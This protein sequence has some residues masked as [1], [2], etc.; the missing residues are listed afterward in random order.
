MIDFS[1]IKVPEP[2]DGSVDPITLFHNLKVSDRGINDLWLAQGDALREWH[3]HRN[4]SDIGIVLNTGAGKTLVGLLVAQS[5][6]NETKGKVL[7]ACSSIQLV[8]Q[9]KEKAEGYGLKASTYYRS[10][11]SDDLYSRCIAPCITTYHALFNGL[12]VFNKEDISAVVFDDSHTAEH[13]LRDH[14]SVLI[15]KSKFPDLYAEMLHIFDDYFAYIGRSV[16]LQDTVEGRSKWVL[17]VPPFEVSAQSNELTRV[18]LD[19]GIQ[20]AAETKFAWAHLK[21]NVDQSC[22]FISSSGVTITPAFV[23]ASSLPYFSTTVR[24]VYLSATMSAPDAFTRTFGKQPSRIV[25]PAT[26]AGECERLIVLPSRIDSSSEG[27]EPAKQLVSTRKALIL[28][29]TYSRAEKWNEVAEPPPRE[30][31]TEEVSAFKNSSEGRKLLLA[32]RYDGVDLPGDTCR[33]MV[34]DDI[35]TGIGSHERYL[36]E[37]LGMDSSLRSMI[38]SRIVQSFGRISRGMSDHGVVVLTGKRL[39]EWLFVPKNL[40]ILPNFLQKQLLLGDQISKELSTVDELHDVVDA[41]LERRGDWLGTY[42]QFMRQAEIGDTVEDSSDLLKLAKAEAKF[43]LMMWKRDYEAAVNSISPTLQLAFSLSNGTGAWHSLWLGF[44][45]DLMGDTESA[46]ELYANAHSNQTSIPPKRRK[47]QAHKDIELPSQVSRIE[48]QMKIKVNNEIS[49]PPKFANNLQFLSRKGSVAQTEE[50]IRY[51]GQYL[52]LNSTRPDKEHGTGP[53]V[54]WI[55]DCGP[56]LCIEAKTEKEPSS[57]YGKDELGQMSDHIQ[58]VIDHHEMNDIVPLFVG[59]ITKP[60][61]R[62]NP[63]ENVVITTLEMFSELGERLV[64][65]LKDAASIATPITLGFHLKELLEER[66]LLYP[67]LLGLLDFRILRNL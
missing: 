60:S 30:Q 8:E 18:L 3:I 53:D 25:A 40:S 45:H 46:N 23:P 9:T 13:L 38:A 22:V 10:R 61:S 63:P 41:C 39:T 19:G 7:Y 42:D 2:Q 51:L 33:L 44:A 64:A 15:E 35:P 49:L 34:I 48:S 52:G 59:P 57:V 55:G 43:G 29:P 27:V 32:A 65:A 21:D 17:F 11:Y 66:D 14:F 37:S 4:D 47:Y 56:A 28:V 1:K 5:L 62:V 36:W 20:E 31:V 50:A 12:S 67:H 54:L 6:V 24:R 58:W 26:S 16:S